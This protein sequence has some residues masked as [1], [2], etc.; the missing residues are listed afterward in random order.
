VLR[1]AQR[2]LG[3]RS[4]DSLTRLVEELNA[5]YKDLAGAMPA[6]QKAAIEGIARTA[7]ERIT[8]S[9]GNSADVTEDW[10]SGYLGRYYSD[11]SERLCKANLAQVERIIAGADGDAVS[12]LRSKLVDWGDARA[13]VMARHEAAMALNKT[14]VAGFKRAGYSSVWRAAPGSCKMCLAMNDVTVTT[15]T[16][17]LHKGCACTVDKGESLIGLTLT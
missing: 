10:L 3:V 16:P 13:E 6:D 8:A 17:P 14:L 9:V 11:T 2:V 4:G 12:A 5:Y 7:M 15:L 1:L